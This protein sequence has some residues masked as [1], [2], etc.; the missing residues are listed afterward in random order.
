VPDQPDLHPDL[1]PLAFLLGTWSGEGHG[2]YPTIE[3]FAYRETVTF[4]HAG[5]AFLTYGQRTTALPDGRPLHAES[6]YWRLAAPGRVEVVLAH[7]F[8]LVEVEEGTL[9]DGVVTL[10]TLHVARTST[11]KEVTEVVR[12]FEVRGDVLTYRVAMAAVGV[13]LTHHL[14]AELHRSVS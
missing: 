9:D 10:R 7:P 11:A 8:G 13:P 5:K 1:A 4:G 12:R 14:A 3:P 2:E 6:G